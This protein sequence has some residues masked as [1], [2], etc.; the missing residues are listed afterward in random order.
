MSVPTSSIGV[1]EAFDAEEMR[2]ERFVAAHGRESISK[3][4]TS[5]EQQSRL[6]SLKR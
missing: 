3:A 2:V 5:D 6:F 4:N 1:H